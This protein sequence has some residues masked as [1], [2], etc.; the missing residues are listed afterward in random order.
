[1]RLR[2]FS[3][4]TL[5]LFNILAKSLL[6]LAFPLTFLVGK[7]FVPYFSVQEMHSSYILH[8]RM[9]GADRLCASYATFCEVYHVHMLTIK[10]RNAKGAFPTCEFCNTV[11]H[12]LKKSRESTD[13]GHKLSGAAQQL[14]LEMMILHRQ[15]QNEEREHLDHLR[16]AATEIDRATR[17]P[18]TFVL[19]TDAISVWRGNT[20]KVGNRQMQNEVFGKAIQW[21][22]RIIG[23]EATCGPIDTIFFYTIDDMQLGGANVMV[24]ALLSRSKFA[25]LHSCTYRSIPS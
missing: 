19:L 5:Y 4:S 13:E 7:K 22:T 17:N 20:P 8:F 3:L 6:S 25:S 23:V 9:L 2:R 16:Q 24:S 15:Q 11:E 21:E 18:K 12:M 1:M 14:L 10:M